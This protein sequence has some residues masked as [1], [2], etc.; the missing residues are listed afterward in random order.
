M[1]LTE[2]NISEDLVKVYNKKIKECTQEYPELGWKCEYITDKYNRF[3]HIKDI[4]ILRKYYTQDDMHI[5]TFDGLF[6]RDILLQCSNLK[7]DISETYDLSLEK[8]RKE[9]KDCDTIEDI[10]NTYNKHKNIVEGKFVLVINPNTD[11]I[12]EETEYEA[13]IMK[14]II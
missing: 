7:R 8:M 12:N 3:T 1:K 11:I 6:Y 4:D 10:I 5:Y 9:L 14:I 13:R 2:I